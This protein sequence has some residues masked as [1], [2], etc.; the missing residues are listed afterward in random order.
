MTDMLSLANVALTYPNGNIGLES[1]S[2]NAK[3]GELI[4]VIGPSGSG[5]TTLLRAVA[6]FLN[7][8]EGMITIGDEVVYQEGSKAVP[9]EKR[10]L[11]MVFQQHAIWPHMTVAQNVNYPLRL[12]GMDKTERAKRVAE[13]LTLV[14]LDGYGDRDPATLS[15]GQRQRVAL[16]RALVNSPRLLLLDEALSALDEPLRD[17]LRLELRSLA[18]TLGLTMLHVT[19]DRNEAIA[20]ADRMIVLDKGKVMQLGTPAE[21]LANPANPFIAGFLSDATLVK[22]TLNNGIFAADDHALTFPVTGHADG[23][24]TLVILPVDIKIDQGGADSVEVQVLSSLFGREHNEVVLGWNGMK[25]RCRYQGEMHKVGDTVSITI[26][27]AR[28]FPDTGE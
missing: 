18:S 25:M 22:G 2:L 9:P 20:L 11:G 14:G 13:I 24:G 12:A 3:K 26:A 19:H 7:P 8:S 28:F 16:A 1:I 17:T 15:G 6:G 10:K 23:H 21:L 4:A 5:K 27:Q